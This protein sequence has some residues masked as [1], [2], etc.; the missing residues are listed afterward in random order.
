M[1]I[2]S[3]AQSAIARLAG[4]R[5]SSVV[6]STD[7]MEVEMTALAHEAAVDMAAG[8]D[9]QALIRQGTIIGTGDEAYALPDDYLRMV[10]GM[11]VSSPQS[12]G[13]SFTGVESLDQWTL[14]RA[15][16]LSITP[17]Y[18]T[19]L[20]GQFN[21][22]PALGEGSS[23][24]FYYITKNLFR[25]E[26]GTPKSEIE[27]DTD[28]FQLDERL[29]TL[30]LIWRWKQMKAM[31]YGEDLRLYEDALSQVQT[32]DRGSRVIRRNSRHVPSNVRVGWPWPLG[33]ET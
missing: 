11:G 3:A 14:I 19:L 8:H 6:S 17:G 26:N 33:G 32:A 13:Q 27:Q 25:D 16:G 30:S 20:G 21:V 10:Q 23:A 2:L 12:P 5:P 28:H 7:E 29:L 15:R 24:A 4:R 9:W 1:S 22:Y 31:D 18:W